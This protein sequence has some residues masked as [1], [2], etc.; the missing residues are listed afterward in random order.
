MCYC[1]SIIVFGPDPGGESMKGVEQSVIR[2]KV[3]GAETK[4]KRLPHTDA[5]M[6]ELTMSRL[7]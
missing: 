5:G 2:E 7:R 6:L 4:S 3:E 1:A